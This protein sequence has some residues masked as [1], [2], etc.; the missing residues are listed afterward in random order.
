MSHTLAALE[1][2]R[3]LTLVAAFARSQRGRQAVLATLPGFSTAEGSQAFSLS[4]ELDVFVAAA[5]PLSFAGLDHASLLAGD[6]TAL[7]ATELARLIS[8]VRTLVEVR[9]ALGSVRLGPE[10]ARRGTSLPHL[11]PFLAH[12]DRCLGPAGEILDSASPQLAQARAARER[13]R[14]AIVSRLDQ[15]RRQH[16][17]QAPFTVRRERYCVPIPSGERQAVGGLVLDVSGTGATAFVEP[18]EVVELNNAL[19]EAL[20]RVREEEQ[21]VLRE[22]AAD[23]A[24]RRDELAAAATTLTELDAFQARAL[25]ARRCDGVL[26]EPGAGSDFRLLGARH[27]LL[28]PRLAGL[29]EEALGEAGNRG[30]VVPLDFAFPANRRVVLLSGPNAGGKTVALK[31]IGLV[32]LMAQA[33]IPVLAAASSALPR[34]SAVWCHIGDEQ[35]LLSDLSTFTG[36]MQATS[37]LLS[38][39][40]TDTLVLY[41]EL[42]SGTD[43]EE[44]AALAASLLEELARRGCWTLATA[45]LVTVAAHVEQLPGATNAAMGYDEDG[46]RPTYRFRLGIPGRSRGL[47]IAAACGVVPRVIARARGLLSTSYLALDGYLSRLEEERRHVEAEATRLRAL[48]AAA[49][50]ARR[51]WAVERDRL[52]RERG[53]VRSS[54]ATER[55][56]LR[57]RAQERLA[58]ALAELQAARARGELPGRRRVAAVRAAAF[59]LGDEEE[60]TTAP[61]LGLA[62]GVRVRVLGT[63]AEGTVG[64]IIGDRVEVQLGGKRVWVARNG[65]EVCQTGPPAPP[66]PAPALVEGGTEPE[67]LKLIGLTEEEARESLDQFLDRALL[68]GLRRVRVVHGH[69]SGTLR[70]MV[71]EVLAAHPAVI[72]FSHPPQ[73]RGGTGVTEAELE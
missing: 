25:F 33:G 45:H 12:C 30:E 17:L 71:R 11:E 49:E 64:R 70:R 15:L 24:R 28:D 53:E 34:F 60:S 55:E 9:D 48:E 29:R 65:C 5:G 6:A 31:T 67:E 22:L 20:S 38:S 10:L 35:S 57:R 56:K 52:E 23:F 7:E 69:G 44:G 73:F 13:H 19:A 63:G 58:A 59:D 26:L 40:D 27:P 18:L 4:R 14:Q 47:A 51:G 72:S 36:A 62:P 61:A 42:G 3:V 1:F 66:P 32:A 21:R 43:P 50:E 2:D 8:L 16:G 54:L 46:G 39:A 68:G 41:D 37:A